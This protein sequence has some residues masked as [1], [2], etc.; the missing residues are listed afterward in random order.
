ME[1]FIEYYDGRR[2]FT[3]TYTEQIPERTVA[4]AL[5]V[6]PPYAF[7]FR[8]FDLVDEKPEVP[9]LG[10]DIVVE[11]RRKR[12]NVS[13]RYYVGGTVYTLAQIEAKARRNKEKWGILA[14]N[15]RGNGWPRVVVTAT[16]NTQAL[17][18]GDCVV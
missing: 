10:P 16:G 7:G 14:S 9:D 11:V 12:L 13:G 1:H 8:F 17:E 5:A 2:F 4:A 3:E 6:L 15:M 18:E